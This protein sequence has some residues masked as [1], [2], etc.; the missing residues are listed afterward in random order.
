MK[1]ILKVAGALVVASGAGGFNRG[2]NPANAPNAAGAANAPP[3]AT[4]QADAAQ[5]T[6]PDAAA[7]P[8]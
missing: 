3:E 8:A 7:P 5:G 4:V 2:G 6:I 1:H